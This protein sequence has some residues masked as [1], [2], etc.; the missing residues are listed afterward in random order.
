MAPQPA[1]GMGIPALR[2]PDTVRRLQAQ[3]GTEK[4]SPGARWNGRKFRFLR[5]RGPINAGIEGFLASKSSACLSAHGSKANPYANALSFRGMVGSNQAPNNILVRGQEQNLPSSL[6]IHPLT[7]R[8][9]TT[10]D[11]PVAPRPL[12]ALPVLPPDA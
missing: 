5:I 4:I 2:S 6:A 3:R 9:S 11:D 7:L 12:A 8:R 1:F 10:P